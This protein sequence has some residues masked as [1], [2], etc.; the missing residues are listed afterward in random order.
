MQILKKKI[1]FTLYISSLLVLILV[2][3]FISI[4]AGY[5]E[6]PFQNVLKTFIGQGTDSDELTI[7]NFR[8]PR[9]IMAILVG[10]GI[11]VSGAILQSISRNPLADPG[12]LGINS[13]AGFMVVFYM[14]FIQGNV[15]YQSWVSVFLMPLIAL[16]G[17]FSA[18]LIIYLLAWK[19]GTIKPTRMIL[20]GI[21]VNAA[22]SAGL[23][24][25]QLKMEPADFTKALIWISGT[26]WGST[27]TYVW[28]IIPWLMILIPF[29]IYKSRTLDLLTLGEVPSIAVGIS[30]EK[31][32]RLLLF[33]SVAL[34]GACVAVGGGITFVGLIAP[35]MARKL[36][37]ASHRRIIPIS[38]C[39]G[40]LLVLVAD[41]IGRVLLAPVELPV[42]IV[43]SV[44]GAPYFI[45][46]LLF[47]Q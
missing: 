6:V 44:I 38:L 30:V 46:L 7:V 15:F 41:T 37:G 16:F 40:A 31:E 18:A 4:N 36:V 12:I 42:G 17:A 21:G 33:V 3:I 5:I 34:A 29:V 13:G 10:A 9:I 8:L 24:I 45:Y 43:I 27:W 11:S 47:K 1:P 39:L 20:V 2:M 22:F 19:K 28:A 14:F 35:H 25:F 23:T 26:I 32:R